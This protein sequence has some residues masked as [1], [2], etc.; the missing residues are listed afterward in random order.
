MCPPQIYKGE[1]SEEYAERDLYVGANIPIHKRT[2]E[3]LEADEFTYQYME[4]NR[5]IF[6]MA[7]PALALKTV[8]AQVAGEFGRPET[9]PFPP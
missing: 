6:K 1:S 9:V 3:L 5:F 7:D 4:N 2:F 8:A